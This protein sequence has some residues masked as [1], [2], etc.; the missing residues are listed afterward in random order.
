MWWPESGRLFSSD[1]V[2]YCS[3]NSE[4]QHRQG[5]G[6]I[7]N[8][9]INQYVDSYISLSDRIIMLR[10][11]SRPVNINLI[12]VYAL[13]GDKNND[14]IGEFYK[15]LEIALKSTKTPEINIVMGDLNAKI[16]C[17]EVQGIVGQYGLGIR[18]DRGDRLIQF[19]QENNFIILNT[20]FK[21]PSR[22]LYTWKSPK[23]NKENNIIIRNQID[24]IMINKRFR[25]SFTEV[26]TYPSVDA[27]TDHNL[28]LGSMNI[29]L[30]I[31]EQAKS[32]PKLD[33]RRLNH[34][35]TKAEMTRDINERLHQANSNS[36][37][38]TVWKEINT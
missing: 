21:L 14:V 33:M 36:D 6:F 12:Q 15:D 9:K 3:G 25:N 7:V 30:K 16:G 26:K 38:E 27:A 11:R 4:Q 35:E 32:R 13:T 22:R 29:R 5:T 19:C 28:L 18:N 37:V 34:F 17:G 2:V 31:I 8:K 1:H 10:I 20:Y 23:D 24:F